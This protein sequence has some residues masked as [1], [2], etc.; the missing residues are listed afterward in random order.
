MTIKY[1]GFWI[2]V[3]A[4]IIDGL[5]FG[6]I[7]I[8]ITVKIYGVAYLDGSHGLIA[9]PADF[10]INWI[11]PSILVIFLWSYW[12]ATPGKMLLRLRVLD[13]V[14]LQ[15]GTTIQYTKRY[16]SMFLSIVFFGIGCFWVAFDGKK[17]GWH[18]KIAGTVVLKI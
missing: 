4:T 17:Q 11:F 10:V 6:I 16:F 13:A 1:A 14:T 8:P 2:R 5:I 7:A 9:G 18:D 15:P 12:Q 3:W